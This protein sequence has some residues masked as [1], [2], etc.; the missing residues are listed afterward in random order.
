MIELAKSLEIS[1]EAAA[2]RYV[3]LHD[4]C[5]AVI[6]S[7]DGVFRYCSR[8]A[9]FPAISLKVGD[10]MPELPR[11]ASGE[12]SEIEEDW[13]TDWLSSRNGDSLTVQTFYQSSGFEIT[14]LTAEGP[15]EGE[16]LPDA[17]SRFQES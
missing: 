2:R 9:S 7:K 13:A 5:V 14:L 16:E 11:R 12:L 4:F 3:L 17:F 1:K 8:Q 15:D 6:Y 10:R